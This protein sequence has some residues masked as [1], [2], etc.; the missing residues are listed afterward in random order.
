[1]PESDA[2]ALTERALAH[3]ETQRKHLDRL[4]CDRIKR[5]T[6]IRLRLNESIAAGREPRL[7]QEERE[8]LLKPIYAL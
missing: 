4:L 8:I 3:V 2:L 7:S 1:M 5:I 6:Q